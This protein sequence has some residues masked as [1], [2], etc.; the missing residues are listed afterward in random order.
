MASKIQEELLDL[1]VKVSG[2]RAPDLEAAS[3]A[4]ELL[5]PLVEPDGTNPAGGPAGGLESQIPVALEVEGPDQI[6]NPASNA[7]LQ[8]TEIARDLK[9]ANAETQRLTV[10]SAFAQ[11]RGASTPPVSA[12][13]SDAAEQAAGRMA[14]A[15]ATGME[16]AF[17]KHE[18]QISDQSSAVPEIRDVA[19]LSP[20]VPMPEGGSEAT[21]LRTL[22]VAFAQAADAEMPSGAIGGNTREESNSSPA[23]ETVS[24]PLSQVMEPR[25][26]SDSSSQSAA[27]S[28]GDAVNT[29]FMAAREQAVDGNYR[30]PAS[31]QTQ[32]Q[33]D[34][35]STIGS[36][37]TGFFE[38][39]LGLVPLIGG[40]MNLFGGGGGSS[41]PPPLVKY[42][43]P[44]SINFEAADTGPGI[45]DSDYDQMG[46]PRLY[47]EA[48]DG[49]SAPS[50]GPF[51]PAGSPGNS[52]A[53][54]Q[55]T[56]NVQAIDARSFLD[57]SSDIAEAVRQ[58]MLNLSS[59]NDVV[60]EL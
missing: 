19:F 42:E 3:G 50:N 31:T 33:S 12:E 25:T 4:S 60:N 56:V 15:M 6:R 48:P 8:V 55:I 21:P 45:V 35:G 13:S 14:D 7:F 1:F 37:V 17:T 5:V 59:L 27:G 20:T 30:P 9:D 2:E 44:P 51:I 16:A 52:T 46:M 29:G 43:M 54:P 34:S 22:D 39:G 11:V 49:F 38:S 24:R 41:A 36:V 10:P 47:T 53:A 32:G 26:A 18:P 40:L 23:L 57:R 58:A 28:S